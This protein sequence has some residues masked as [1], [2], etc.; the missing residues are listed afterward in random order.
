MKWIQCTSLLHVVLLFAGIRT[1][2]YSHL[3]LPAHAAEI[4]WGSVGG[5]LGHKLQVRRMEDGGGGPWENEE[6]LARGRPTGLPSRNLSRK[7][8]SGQIVRQ[9][10]SEEAAWRMFT[11]VIAVIAVEP[12]FAS[13]AAA[14]RARGIL[15][16]VRHCPNYILSCFAAE[17][18]WSVGFLGQSC[19]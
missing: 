3:R 1:T 15:E 16:W 6:M 8:I 12:S 13:A 5:S 9:T 11:F 14:A 10:Y 17:S 18:E 19:D 2:G 7:P 4:E